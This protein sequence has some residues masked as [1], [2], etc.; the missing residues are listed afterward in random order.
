ME[1][2]Q[3]YLINLLCMTS[4]LPLLESENTGVYG[5]P[6]NFSR[7]SSKR[8]SFRTERFVLSYEPDA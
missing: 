7:L 6:V 1:I 8:T 5:K 2:A 4:A 3:S